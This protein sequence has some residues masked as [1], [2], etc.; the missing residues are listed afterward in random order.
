MNDDQA[1]REEIIRASQRVE[2]FLQTLG[3]DDFAR[4]GSLPSRFRR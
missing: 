3:P 4:R 1:R 2:S